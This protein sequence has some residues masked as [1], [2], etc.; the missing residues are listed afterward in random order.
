MS[1]LAE[2][3]MATII[4]ISTELDFVFDKTFM[5]TIENKYG[6]NTYFEYEIIIAAI[7]MENKSYKRA[8]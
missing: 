5:N 2:K 1:P 3:Q 6:N 8:C 7:N 4:R